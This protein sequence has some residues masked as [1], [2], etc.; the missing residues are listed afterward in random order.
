M[1]MSWEFVDCSPHVASSIKMLIKPGGNAYFQAFNFAN[2]RHTIT[3]VQVNGERLRLGT[4]N[5][6]A[7]SP[8]RCEERSLHACCLQ[9]RWWCEMMREISA[10]P[11]AIANGD[12]D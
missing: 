1:Q 2:P 6:W 11:T 3:A 4:D 7:W 9:L 8:S 5:F 12:Y 10:L